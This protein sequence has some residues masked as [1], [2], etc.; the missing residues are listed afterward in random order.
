MSFGTYLYGDGDIEINAGRRTLTVTVSNTG[1]R[2][3]QV[4]SHYHFF[5]VNPALR[6]D[7]DRTLGTHLNIPAGTSVRIEPGGTREVELCEY[8]GTG[9][10]V[11]FSGLLNG[12]TVSHPARI[13]AFRR[14]YADGFQGAENSSGDQGSGD[15]GPGGKGTDGTGTGGK[16]TGDKGAGGKGTGGKGSAKKKGG[17]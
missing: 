9:R 13:E 7:R 3:V 8:G 6:F 1:D 10:L 17:N 15:R 4:G 14:A 2:A 16:R 11:G 5:E 12:S